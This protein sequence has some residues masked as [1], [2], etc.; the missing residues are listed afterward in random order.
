MQDK[1]RFYQCKNGRFYAEECATIRRESLG[2]KNE[3]EVRR[4]IAA[5]NQAVSQPIFILR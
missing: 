5:K 2:T 3:V 1:F 4:L